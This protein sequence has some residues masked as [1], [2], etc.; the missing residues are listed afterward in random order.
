ML[1]LLLPPQKK[2]GKEGAS[3]TALPPPRTPALPSEARAPHAG[4]PAAAK[5]S[6]ARAR[7]KEVKKE[8]RLT[9]PQPLGPAGSPRPG[10]V[11]S[12]CWQMG[13]AWVCPPFHTLLAPGQAVLPHPT[14]CSWRRCL[15]FSKATKAPVMVTNSTEHRQGEGPVLSSLWPPGSPAGTP[16]A[17]VAD[18]TTAS[19]SPGVQGGSPAGQD[20]C[21]V[22]S[23]WLAALC[24]QN[25]GKGG[26]VSKLMESMAAEE[27]FEPN[28]DS[29]FS[30]DE[31]LPRGG[32]AERPLTPGECPRGCWAPAWGGARG[33]PRGAP[34][35]GVV[36]KCTD[37][38]LWA[39]AGEGSEQGHADSRGPW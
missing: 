15:S 25:R 20:R 34:G 23:C 36:P 31:H 7:G 32:A 6:K 30:E 13:P 11:S 10:W 19:L 29:S 38:A 8:V 35:G 18:S 1:P 4:S 39:R 2:K 21:C 3:G 24:P 16:T 28:Q 22:L 5:R 17:H 14:A 33:T 9:A 27:D 12:F 26:A 37:M